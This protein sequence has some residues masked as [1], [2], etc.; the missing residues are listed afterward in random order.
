MRTNLTLVYHNPSALASLPH[1]SLTSNAFDKM[2]VYEENG[3]Y[4]GG[5]MIF[6]FETSKAPLDIQYVEMKVRRALGI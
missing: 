2:K 1:T 4:D 6:S 5:C 3:M